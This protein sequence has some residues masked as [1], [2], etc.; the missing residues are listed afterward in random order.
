MD[1]QEGEYME[2]ICGSVGQGG[3]QTSI[4]SI[5]WSSKVP[6][7]GVGF[8]PARHPI[9]RGGVLPSRGGTSKLLSSSP[10]PRVHGRSPHAGNQPPASQEG[11][12]GDPQPKTV[13]LRKLDSLTSCH[14]TPSCR[15]PGQDRV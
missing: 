15:S 13:H 11:R 2:R 7:T 14:R 1:E 9:N 6:Q 12:A 8:S 4:D 10:F 5:C 3:A